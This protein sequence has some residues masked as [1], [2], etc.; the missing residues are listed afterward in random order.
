MES[1]EKTVNTLSNQLSPPPSYY[2]FFNNDPDSVILERFE[3][4]KSEDERKRRLLEVSITH[5]L[6]DV[7]TPDLSSHVK[8][9]LSSR[10]QIEHREIDPQLIAKKLPRNNTVLVIFSDYKF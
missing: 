1:L 9:F 4:V 2:S 10:M 6:I 7:P 5:P 3:R 8:Q